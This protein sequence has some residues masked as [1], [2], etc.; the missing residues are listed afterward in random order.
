MNHSAIGFDNDRVSSLFAKTYT[1]NNEV[2]P[3]YIRDISAGA[4]VTNVLDFSLFVKMLFLHGSLGNSCILNEST[5][6]QM[7]TPQN[8]DVLLDFGM[9]MGLAYGLTNGTRVPSKVI[10]HNGGIPS[11]YSSFV[12]FPDLKLGFV[13]FI[14]SSQG[15]PTEPIGKLLET[16]YEAKTGNKL[17]EQL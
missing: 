13:V 14:N 12:A 3:L 4:I 5:L 11:F 16:F 8:S 1:K 7:W 2:D 6:N 17:P 9:P 10:G 15:D